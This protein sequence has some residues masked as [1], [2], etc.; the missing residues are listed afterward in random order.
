[1]DA[2]ENETMTRVG[3]GTPAGETLRRYWLPVL[4]SDEINSEQPK[5]VRRLAEDLLL[6]RDEFGRVGLTEPTCPHRG[7]SLEYGWIEAGGIRCCYHGWVYDVN[8]RCIDQPGEPSGSN[9]K[10]KI[11]LK[12]YPTQEHGGIVWAYM[13]LGE[14][15]PFPRYDFLV[16][17]D[18]ERTLNG[19]LRECNFM[20]Q[21]D[22]CLDPVHA[23]ILHGRD[24]N[25]VRQNPE[26]AESPE[27][28]VLAD[29][30]FA[31]YVARRQG[32]E[33]GKEWHREVSYTPPILVVHDGGSLPGDSNAYFADVAWRYACG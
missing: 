5:I 27:F 31:S 3:P 1:M 24:V 6:F 4:F 30:L 20:N 25:G 11:K 13:G 18:G 9:F 32:P 21:L 12:A 26:R 33:P 29:D 16:R 8:G 19:Y 10:D 17:D 15:P 14:P 23:T 28:E 2:Q 7:T 22:N